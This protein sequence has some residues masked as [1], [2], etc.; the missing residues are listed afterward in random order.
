MAIPRILVLNFSAVSFRKR[1]S[2]LDGIT[3]VVIGFCPTVSDTTI[4]PI[5]EVPSVTETK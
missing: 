1:D 2:D 4:D 5:F 3:V